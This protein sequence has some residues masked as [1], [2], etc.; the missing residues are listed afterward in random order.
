MAFTYD[1]ATDTGRVRML[2]PDRDSATHVF[3][4]EELAAFLLFGGGVL[5]AAALALETAAADL[6]LTLRVTSVLGLSVNGA[7]ASDA[8]LRRAEKL[9][10]VADDTDAREGGAFDWA[11]WVVDPFSLAERLDAQM[12]RALP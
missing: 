8:L 12:R 5:R 11:E 2:I 1:V 6:A 10:T 4:D 7:A 9:R 3:E